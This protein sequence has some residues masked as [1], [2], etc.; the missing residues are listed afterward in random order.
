MVCYLSKVLGRS[1][2]K[3]LGLGGTLSHLCP[4]TPAVHSCI[5]SVTVGDGEPNVT[6]PAAD[7]GPC[8]PTLRVRGGV[9]SVCGGIH[10]VISAMMRSAV[11]DRVYRSTSNCWAGGSRS[12]GGLC[13]LKGGGFQEDAEALTL[14]WALLEAGAAV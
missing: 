13:V 1:K 8:L 5:P 10:I 9:G 11:G 4:L 2:E 3:P 7:A 6:E 12:Q 14:G